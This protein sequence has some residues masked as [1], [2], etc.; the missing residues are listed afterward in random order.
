MGPIQLEVLKQVVLD[1]FGLT[2]SFGPCRI[3][4]ME[5]LTAPVVGMAHY[6]PLRHYAEGHLLLE[7]GPRGSGIT[8][9]SACPLEVLTENFQRL[10]R[11]H[12]FEKEHKGVLIG[13]PLTDIKVTL[14]AGRSHLKHTE[15]G[16]FRQ[17][18]YRAIRHGLARGQSLLL[19]PWYH[20]MI[21][22]PGD[23]LGRI[24]ADIQRMHGEFEPPQ[25]NG[26][27]VVIYGRGPVASFSNYG[28]E[29]PAAT[30]GR[31][32]FTA[33]FGGYEPCHNADE[34]IAAAE[35]D[36]DADRENAAD[37]VF[38]AKGAGFL[39]P[40]REAAGYMHIDPATYAPTLKKAGLEPQNVR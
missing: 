19:E 18:V 11:T 28:T 10:I 40:W 38:C 34:V 6:E 17:V 14:L 39:V 16:D 21:T 8:F 26:E 12:V 1:R 31:G 30:Q 27:D 25:M 22:A 15:G 20:F 35:Y 2:I 24:M 37:S 5:T 32:Q 3:A 4:Y 23:Y 29:L 9:A 7:A 36:M 33:S 13:A